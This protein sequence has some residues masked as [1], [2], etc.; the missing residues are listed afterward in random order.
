M[1][2]IIIDKDTGQ[3]LWR[4]SDC[5]TYCNIVLRT[6]SHYYST[7]RTPQ[8]VATLGNL[9]LWD[10]HTVKEWHASRPRT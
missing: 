9:P 4:S 5:A 8:P 7:G 2:P 3:E 6:W 10:A 1:T